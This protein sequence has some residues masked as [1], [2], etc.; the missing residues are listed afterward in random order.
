MVRDAA[1]GASPA[2]HPPQEHSERR[3]RHLI[4]CLILCPNVG[5]PCSRGGQR[6]GG[7]GA[8]AAG[9]RGCSWRWRS[10]AVLSPLCWLGAVGLGPLG[11]SS[12]STF[13]P[14]P[15]ASGKSGSVGIFVIAALGGFFFAFAL[16]QLKN[17]ETNLASHIYFHKVPECPGCFANYL[18]IREIFCHVIKGNKEKAACGSPDQASVSRAGTHCAQ[19]LSR[20]CRGWTSGRRCLGTHAR[21]GVQ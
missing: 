15:A 3:H 10:G 16:M 21:W 7:T 4:K 19:P 6:A 11:L 13:P 14:P 5:Q 9:A 2:R 8:V 18:Q 17:A 12:C 1:A 20:G